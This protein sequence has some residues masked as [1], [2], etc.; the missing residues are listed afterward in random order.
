[1]RVGMLI[2]HLEEWKTKNVRWDNKVR[3]VCGGTLAFPFLELVW[4]IYMFTST[5]CIV[6][7]LTRSVRRFCTSFIRIDDIL[8]YCTSACCALVCMQTSLQLGKIW[9]V[10]SPTLLMSTAF[11]K[12]NG[13]TCNRETCAPFFWCNYSRVGVS[14]WGLFRNVILPHFVFG[15]VWK[16]FQ[17]HL[18]AFYS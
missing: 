14:Y 4:R 8:W 6:V 1:M 13:L 17:R 16:V 18:E 10:F 9:E 2:D 3:S 12:S 15:V 7:A 11:A 5:V